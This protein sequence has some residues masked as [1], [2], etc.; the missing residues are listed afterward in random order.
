[1]PSPFAFD[2]VLSGKASST[3]V[4]L[5]KSKQRIVMDLIYGLADYPGQ[6]GDYSTRD[7]QGHDIQ[8][9][10]LGDWHFPT[11]PT[12]PFVNLGLQKSLSSKRPNQTYKPT[13]PT[14]AA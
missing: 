3:I 8:H 1:M 9:I 6:R 5:S 7:D 13:P 4:G 12:V 14:G 11:G 2:P 10:R